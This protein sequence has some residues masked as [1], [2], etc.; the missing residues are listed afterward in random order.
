[1]KPTKQIPTYK[2]EGNKFIKDGFIEVPTVYKRMDWD[3]ELEEI[4]KDPIFNDVEI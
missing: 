3:K 4:L 1:M 2:K